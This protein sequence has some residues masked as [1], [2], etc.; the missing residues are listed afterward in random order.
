MGNTG[1]KGDLKEQAQGHCHAHGTA[2]PPPGATSATWAHTRRWHWSG[3]SSKDP[4]TSPS[5]TP[6]RSQHPA[7]HPGV[8]GTHQ[9]C[10]FL[11]GARKAP[12][13]TRSWGSGCCSMACPEQEHHLNFQ[14]E[15]A[16]HKAFQAIKIISKAPILFPCKTKLTK[17]H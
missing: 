4:S 2:T 12:G 1:S 14:A 7:E 6:A 8:Q 3:F 11:P 5:L 16:L 15:G 9:T 17:L 13:T 10:S